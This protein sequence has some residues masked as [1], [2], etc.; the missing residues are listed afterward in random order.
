ML[1][2]G[3]SMKKVKV[4][5]CGF[6]KGMKHYF[7][8]FRLVE[9]QRTFYKPP[10]VDTALRWRQE[11]PADF[12]FAIKAW[13]PITHPCSSPTYRK[14]GLNIPPGKGGN[15]GFF[16]P[17]EEVMEAWRKTRE[18]AEALRARVIVFQCPPS[19]RE[20]AQ[21]LENMRRFFGAV[22]RRF[23]F[24]WEPRGGW[25]ERVV[26]A[27]CEELEL[28][29]CVDPMEGEPL[30]GERRYFRLHGG[31]GYGHKYSD[32]ELKWLCDRWGGEEAY[33]LF[34]N[35]SMYEDALR[36]ERLLEGETGDLYL[37]NEQPHR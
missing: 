6:A 34:N 4:G 26:K 14:A 11:A 37:G 1:A 32:G 21:N 33:F 20:E 8:Q 29:H 30:Y 22:E 23:L 31:P 15:Y 13:Q 10:Q 17:T 28:V 19:F 18:I 7:P 5:C 9:V 2:E 3:L 12:E 35:L 36:F 27:L 25:S 16:K 24:V